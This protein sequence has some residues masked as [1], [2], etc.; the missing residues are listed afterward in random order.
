MLALSHEDKQAGRYTTAVIQQGWPELLDL[1]FNQPM[2]WLAAKA[3]MRALP[4]K[5]RFHLG[6]LRRRLFSPGSS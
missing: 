2:G 1:P 4:G 5:A 3:R 6:G